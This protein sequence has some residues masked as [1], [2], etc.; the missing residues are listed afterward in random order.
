MIKTPA[1]A[2]LAGL[3]QWVVWRTVTRDGKPTKVLVNPKTGTHASSTDPKTWSTYDHATESSPNYDGVGFVF[4]PADPYTGVDLDHCFHE[5]G[6]LA[7]WAQEIVDTLDSYTEYSP[8]G[9]GLHIW[10]RATLPPGRRRKGGVEMYD[11]GRYFTITGKP[12]PGCRTTIEERQDEIT[13]LHARIFPPV[14]K[15]SPCAHK[16]KPGALRDVSDIQLLERATQAKNGD[17]FGRLYAGDKSAHGG[18]SSGADQALCNLLAFWTGCD[19]TRMDS[20]FRSSG[21][22]RAKWDERHSSDGRTYGQMTLEKAIGDCAE[23]YSPEDRS[24][25]NGAPSAHHGFGRDLADSHRPVSAAVAPIDDGNPFEEIPESEDRLRPLTLEE[26]FRQ[27]EEAGE[28]RW[29][30][31][32]GIAR[33]FI[34]LLSAPPKS[35]KT[36]FGLTLAKAVCTG[37][38][39][40]GADGIEQGPVLWIDEEM[41]A[42][43]MV[44]RL[45]QLEFHEDLPFHTISLAGFR[46]DQALDVSR[47]I[48]EVERIGAALIVVDSLRRCHHLDENDNSQMRHLLPM[49]HALANTGAAVVVIHH[50]RK[51]TLNDSSEQERSSGALDLIAQVDMVFGMRRDRDTFTLTCRSARLVGEEQAAS[52]A[53]RLTD[54]D[55][56]T[57]SVTP[58]SAKDQKE[59]SQVALET[60][61]LLHLMRSPGDNTREIRE[62][63]RA[64]SNKVA[65]ALARMTED[66]RLLME[67]GNRGAKCYR[68]ADEPEFGDPL[69]DE[70]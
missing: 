11:Q 22:Y 63:V 67:I 60:A 45:R 24:N 61:I 38:P 12:Y 34:H 68:C 58:L 57:V 18:D 14:E 62:G 10:I 28:I 37:T 20:L 48:E 51:R 50:D 3:P 52:I 5:D 31:P 41:G 43:L 56:G 23:V 70:D 66:G 40:A 2:E 32:N 47:V 25:G 36:W 7:P 6:E 30:V 53:F 16:P 59:N 46:L 1:I 55:D 29:V 39:W 69:A 54:R 49:L 13:A 42:P 19:L 15:P 33:G 35:G 65:S 8:S 44:R 27:A 9:N 17:L 4:W 21:L 26:L 64:D